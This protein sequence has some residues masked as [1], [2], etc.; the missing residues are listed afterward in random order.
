[1]PLIV[2]SLEEQ[3]CRDSGPEGARQPHRLHRRLRL[4]KRTVPRLLARRRPQGEG[5]ALQLPPVPNL[6]CCNDSDIFDAVSVADFPLSGCVKGHG[7]FHA[8]S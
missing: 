8:T 4:L 7:E 1:M 6:V 2:S 5:L 3:H